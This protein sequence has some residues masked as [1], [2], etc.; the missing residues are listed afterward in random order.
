MTPP[1]PSPE[2]KPASERD[3]ETAE[4]LALAILGAPDLG[5]RSLNVLESRDLLLSAL[6][7]ARAEG[8]RAGIEK[9]I[10]N[11]KL[12]M[13]SASSWPQPVTSDL[14]Y[15]IVKRLNELAAPPPQD[16]GSGGEQAEEK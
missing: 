12:T 5:S 9:A 13:A 6:A 16:H 7:A 8:E 14:G 4:R 11:V 3:M 15:W 2:E 1:K 10:E